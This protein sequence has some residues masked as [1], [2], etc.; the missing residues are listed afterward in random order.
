MWAQQDGLNYQAVIRDASGNL[1]TNQSVVAGFQ[2]LEST[3]TG[4]V[5]YEETHGLMTNNYG[6]INAV[7]GTGSVV[8]GNFANIDWGANPHFL[9][10]SIDGNSLGTIEFKSVP[11]S[12]HAQ[13]LTNIKTNT[14]NSDVEITSSDNHALLSLRPTAAFNNDSSEIFLGEGSDYVNGMT[15]RY[16][17]VT[18]SLRIL[19]FD[20]TVQ[21]DEILTIGRS[22]Q[23]ANFKKGIEVRET[24]DAPIPNR[25]YG[26]STPIAYGFIQGSGNLATDYGVLSVNVLT[27]GVY[28]VTFD[29]TFVG[30][31]V[32]TA[33]TWNNTPDTEVITYQATSG[34]GGNTITFRIVDENNTAVSS[35]FSFVI[36]GIAQ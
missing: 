23:I 32:I 29:R 17:G 21:G 8:S 26:N 18:N 33:T 4:T 7:I 28:E 35:D 13:T 14:P 11:Y 34:G 22:N 15:I 19:S 3:A 31:P 25:I 5:V 27:T 9:A 24:T 2:I 10:I 1:L 30:Y 36:Y 12:L 16:E 20:G 6:L